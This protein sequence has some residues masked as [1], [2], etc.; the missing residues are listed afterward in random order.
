MFANIICILLST[1]VKPVADSSTH[2][3]VH[4]QAVLVPHPNLKKQVLLYGLNMFKEKVQ[5]VI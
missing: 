5:L 4:E 1:I 3:W 2:A